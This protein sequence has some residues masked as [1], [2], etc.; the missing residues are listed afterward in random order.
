M[1]R[2]VILAVS[3]VVV[4]VLVSGYF[5]LRRLGDGMCGNYIV[6]QLQS[7]D[8]KLKAVLF[9]RDCGATTDFSTQVSILDSRDSLRNDAGNVFVAEAGP[10]VARGPWHGPDAR[11]AFVGAQDLSVGFAQGSKL[12]RTAQR[13]KG[14]HVTYY[15]LPRR[16][17]APN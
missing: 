5:F 6:A 10:G 4:A 15:V 16:A 13:V 14:V 11:I 9:Q 12:Y 7:P 3:L 1:V 17:S 2:T 8:A